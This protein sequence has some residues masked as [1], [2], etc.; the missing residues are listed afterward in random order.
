MTKALK[1]VIIG[2]FSAVAI[3]LAGL[4]FASCTYDISNVNV[5]ASVSSLTL[6]LGG[7]NES[8][9]VTFTINNAPDSF[10]KTLRFNVDNEGVV[11]IS[12][13]TYNENEVTITIT[14]LAGGST[15][16]MA[17][18]EEG[19]RYTSIRVN[20]IQHSNTMTFNNSSLYLSNSTPFVANNGYYYFDS[21]TTDKEMTFYYIDTDLSNYTFLNITDNE[22][23]FTNNSNSTIPTVESFVAS[24]VLVFIWVKLRPTFIMIAA[25]NTLA[26]HSARQPNFKTGM[27]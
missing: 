1:K 14:A 3:L 5:T 24:N 15:N 6:E 18:T 16:I 26:V 8:Q 23:V 19:Y 21:N 22:I 10:T 4:F 25:A 11:D 7:M 27:T 13:P 20:V 9:D 12:S 2:A 17:I